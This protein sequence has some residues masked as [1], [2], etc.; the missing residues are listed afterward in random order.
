MV[1]ALPISRQ[2]DNRP[3]HGL[4]RESCESAVLSLQQRCRNSLFSKF[5]VVSGFHPPARRWT[6]GRTA[7]RPYRLGF[8]R[9]GEWTGCPPI[10]NLNLSR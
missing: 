10:L 4:I 3:W 8:W 5:D 7:V 1:R 6:G 2:L 9:V